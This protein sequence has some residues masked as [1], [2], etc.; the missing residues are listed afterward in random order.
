MTV[1]ERAMHAWGSKSA[2][3]CSVAFGL[4]SMAFGVADIHQT[5]RGE[6]PLGRPEVT[7]R[8]EHDDSGLSLVLRGVTHV[9][10]T[11]VCDNNAK[12]T[13]YWDIGG[14]LIVAEAKNA[15]GR[16]AGMG[17]PINLA[18]EGD[19]VELRFSEV[20]VP[21]DAVDYVT[22][23]TAPVGSCSPNGWW[24]SREQSRITIPPRPKVQH[25]G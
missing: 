17:F 5:D 6:Y 7:A 23:V 11:V 19:V 24:G 16:P 4:I 25:D 18:K 22:I 1:Y 10:P 13:R 14:V 9:N 20:E 2:V 12:L 15:K 21:Y 8:W 3:V